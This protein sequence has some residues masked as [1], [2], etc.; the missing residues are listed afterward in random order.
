MSGNL[1]CHLG[2]LALLHPEEEEPLGSYEH[3]RG[4]R[5]GDT[6]DGVLRVGD[7]EPRFELPGSLLIS[8]CFLPKDG[9]TSV[10]V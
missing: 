7:L 5:F 6:L 10:G 4:L 9:H 2:Q 1:A 3:D 8:F